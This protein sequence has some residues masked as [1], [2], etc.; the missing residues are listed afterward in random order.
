MST[1]DS[2]DAHRLSTALWAVAA[3]VILEALASE[4][5]RSR[6]WALGTSGLP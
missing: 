1:S 2:A 6:R 5:F 3:L 4:H